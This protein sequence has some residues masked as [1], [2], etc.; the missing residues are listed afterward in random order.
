M[1]RIIVG[2]LILTLVILLLLGCSEKIVL[3]GSSSDSYLFKMP[4][5]GLIVDWSYEPHPIVPET[6]LF[7]FF[8]HSI[9][10]DYEGKLKET[11][12]A[13]MLSQVLPPGTT[14]GSQAISGG[15]GRYSIKVFAANV[16]SWKITILPR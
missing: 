14:S 10:E 1:K 15:T 13:M 6:T 2:I 4:G 12:C 8:V 3:T 5:D 7:S 16:E 11:V 9:E